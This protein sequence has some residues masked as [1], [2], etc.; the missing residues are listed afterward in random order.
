MCWNLKHHT[1]CAMWWWGGTKLVI[2][3]RWWLLLQY[4]SKFWC[5]ENIFKSFFSVSPFSSLPSCALSLCVFHAVIFPLWCH[6][7][8]SLNFISLS[9]LFLGLSVPSLPLSF[10]CF[11]RIHILL[12]SSSHSIHGDG[13][14]NSSQRG[15]PL[16]ASFGTSRLSEA[17]WMRSFS[18]LWVLASSLCACVCEWLNSTQRLA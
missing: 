2:L 9:P 16:T 13:G 7:T 5:F 12:S 4:F 3:K 1:H 14:C 8:L 17:R 11:V 15:E 10:P 6:V 18:W